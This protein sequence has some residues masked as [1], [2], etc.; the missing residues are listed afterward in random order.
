MTTE[1]FFT[2]D[3]MIRITIGTVIALA[4][5]GVGMYALAQGVIHRRMIY[6][7]ESFG[8]LL[9][10]GIGLKVMVKFWIGWLRRAR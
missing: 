3:L 1:E 6:I 4:V 5:L 9:L 7:V 2:R 8:A 10:G